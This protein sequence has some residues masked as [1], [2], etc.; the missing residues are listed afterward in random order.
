M[1]RIC[2]PQSPALQ[3]YIQHISFSE[4]EATHSDYIPVVPDAM[5]ELV[6]VCEGAYKRML[7]GQESLICG[8][9]FIGLKSK[10]AFVKSDQ[11][12]KTISIRFKPGAVRFFTKI[13]SHELVDGVLDPVLV[14]GK[15]F[16]DFEQKSGD[17]NNTT[18]CLTM[19]ESFLLS[20]FCENEKAEK[21]RKRILSTYKNPAFSSV[22]NLQD[23][24]DSYKSLEREFKQNLGISPKAF[25]RILQFNYAT[26]QLTKQ[27]KSSPFTEIGYICGYFDQSHF[28]RSFKNFSTITPTEY[29]QSF[30]Q[31]MKRNQQVINDCFL[32]NNR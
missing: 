25:L 26:Y 9:H 21:T 29:V 15:K 8:S 2:T 30:D 13:H 1:M 7:S 11:H 27:V 16:I 10:P 4:F 32:F 17:I 31:M 22:E 5:T 14:F 20:A 23:S 19:V 18:E 28:I 6:I 24:C 3:K 12:V